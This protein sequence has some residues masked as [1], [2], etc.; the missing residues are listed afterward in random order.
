MH[1]ESQIP[2]S[3]KNLTTE[4]AA[5]SFLS[6]SKTPEIPLDDIALVFKRSLTAKELASFEL[7]LAYFKKDIVHDKHVVKNFLS[8]INESLVRSVNDSDIDVENKHFI[9]SQ[10]KTAMDSIANNFDA[11]Y[12]ILNSL[13]KQKNLLDVKCFTLII[14]GYAISLLKKIYNSTDK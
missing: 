12:N 5:D 1:P 2:S 6:V 8:L 14:A 9:A 13:N 7:G 4:K 11:F 10:L 3:I